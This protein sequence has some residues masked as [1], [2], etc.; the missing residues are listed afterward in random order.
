MRDWFE[1]RGISEA[2]VARHCIALQHAYLPQLEDE[3]LCIVFPY[4]RQGEAV[5]LKYRSLE[6]KH[7]RQVSGAEKILYGLDDLTEDWAVIVEGECDKLALEVS[8]ICNAVSVP[9]GAPPANSKPSDAKFEYLTNCA[10]HLDPL[11]KIVLAVDSDAPGR[12]LEAELARRLGPERCFRV[13]WP[14][15]CKDANEVLVQ[16]GADELRRCITEAKPYPLEG[17]LQVADLAGDVMSLYQ[18]GLPGGMSTGWSSVDQHYTV[19]PGELTIVTGIPSHGKSQF[20][21]ALTVNLARDHEWAIAVCSPENLPVSRHI[22]KLVEQYTGWPFRQGP[23]RRMTPHE[24]VMALDWLHQHFVFIA[25]DE[26]LTIPALLQHAKALVARHGIRG[27]ILDPWNEFDHARGTTT[28]T[29]YISTSLTQIRRFARTYGVHVWLVAHPQKLY[30]RDDG[31]Y[32]VPTPY[33]ISGSAHWRNKADN[34][35]AVWRDENDPDE[36]VHLYVQKVRFREV[37]KIG[38]VPLRWSSVNG[39]YAEALPELA[40]R[41]GN[42]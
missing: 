2:I 3:A 16:R 12:T 20:L 13:R 34:C 4:F 1:K 37:G 32:P 14:E 41:W 25:P 9:D 42:S 6:G 19:R 40:S 18:E 5:N 29:E 7:F 35:L 36:P 28:E 30:R 24:L 21:D 22:A 26:A 11:K 27:L 17:V 31:S 10:A 33:D 39:R 23:T 8:G 15:G 38:L